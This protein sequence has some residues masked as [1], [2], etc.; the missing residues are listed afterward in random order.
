[1]LR[2]QFARRNLLFRL[3]LGLQC[4]VENPCLVHNY[5]TVSKLVQ[6]VCGQCQTILRNCHKFAYVVNCERMLTHPTDSFLKRNDHSKSKP[7]NHVI[8][9]W[10]PRW[11]A[12]SIPHRP[13]PYREFSNSL[14][15]TTSIVRLEHSELLVFYASTME[16][17]NQF[18]SSVKLIVQT[19]HS[20][21]QNYSW[22]EYLFISAKN[23]AW[24]ALKFT[25]LPALNGCE[26]QTK[27]CSSIKIGYS[28]LMDDCW[29]E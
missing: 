12:L 26:T 16:F 8:S 2:H 25:Q 23:F 18:L 14:G 22:Y 9:L 15:I 28:Q 10:L 4:I 13:T 19:P 17:I 6:I 7:P 3:L 29:R 11:H 24:W 1:M 21:Y 20:I 5:E 27:R